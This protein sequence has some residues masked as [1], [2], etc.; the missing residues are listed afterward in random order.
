VV[1]TG[2]TASFGWSALASTAEVPT[3]ITI[4]GAPC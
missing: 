3:D 4:N 2:G 1:P